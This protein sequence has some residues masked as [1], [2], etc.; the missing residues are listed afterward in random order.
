LSL[1]DVRRVY[2]KLWHLSDVY[3]QLVELDRMLAGKYE[4]CSEVIADLFRHMDGSVIDT[5]RG[6]A[7]LTLKK[8]FYSELV[9]ESEAWGRVTVLPMPIDLFFFRLTQLTGVVAERFGTFR[10]LSFCGDAF[11]DE[12]VR[13]FYKPV[14]ILRD[15]VKIF[16]VCKNIAFNVS[17]TDDVFGMYMTFYWGSFDDYDTV[18]LPGVPGLRSV[19]YEVLKDASVRER[20]MELPLPE[21][22]DGFVRRYLGASFDT[23]EKY[24]EKADEA[25]Y[26]VIDKIALL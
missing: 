1:E 7:S 8:R 18:Y 6:P 9:V 10:L 16:V 14:H 19:F 23:I 26:W 13:V 5:C 4:D 11:L 15:S 2:K 3:R 17:R 20:S 22:V 25:L 24:V 12:S 21:S